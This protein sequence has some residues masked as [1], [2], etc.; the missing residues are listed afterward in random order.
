MRLIKFFLSGVLLLYLQILFAPKL[1]ILGVVPFFLIPYV[2]F[3]SIHLGLLESTII[4]FLIGLSFDLINPLLLGANTF[5]LLLLTYFVQR[6]HATVNKDKFIPILINISIIN[7]FYFIPLVFIRTVIIEFN[8]AVFYLFLV[9][10]I[11]NIV[12]TIV[13]LYLFT[14]IHKLKLVI[15]V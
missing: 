13:S 12:I 8:A 4:T 5:L 1:A 9:E 11:Y 10:L 2:I 6:Y 7:V 14:I 15:D 3:V